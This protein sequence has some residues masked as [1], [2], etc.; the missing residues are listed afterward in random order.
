MQVIIVLA[1]IGFPFWVVFSWIYDLTP[2]GI[3]KTTID[4][5][6]IDEDH[7]KISK[8]LNFV[9]IA[10]LSVVIV[11]LGYNHFKNREYIQKGKE[12]IDANFGQSVAVLPFRNT[13][14]DPESDYF[15]F[16]MADQIIGNLNYLKNVNV[17][18]SASVRKYI[19]KEP[20][21]HL[22]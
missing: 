1:V 9:I 8:R 18:S 5:S 12:I 17:I 3:K 16:A 22:L 21:L 11:L 4:D 6:I 19:N 14:P 20:G 15:G 10:S 7:I 13:K 2:E